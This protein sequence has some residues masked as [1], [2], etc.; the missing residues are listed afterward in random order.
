MGDRLQC[1]DSG[2]G[3]AAA[4]LLKVRGSRQGKEEKEGDKP[5]RS[6]PSERAPSV[7]GFWGTSHI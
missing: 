1:T 7:G 2:G 4:H 6:D 3:G 5:F